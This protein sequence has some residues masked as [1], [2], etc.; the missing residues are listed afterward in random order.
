MAVSGPSLLA[1]LAAST[2][3]KVNALTAA[4][5]ADA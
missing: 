4:E 1:S 5:P 3:G 2:F